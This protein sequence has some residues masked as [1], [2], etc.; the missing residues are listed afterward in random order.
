M[1]LAAHRRS[2][3]LCSGALAIAAAFTLTGCE[4]MD[5]F[6][7]PLVGDPVCER[8]WNGRWVPTG[9]TALEFEEDEIR[10]DLTLSQPPGCHGST[11]AFESCEESEDLEDDGCDTLVATIEFVRL[12]ERVFANVRLVE[13]DGE[14]LT[15]HRDVDLVE[16]RDV[17]GSK[18]AFS[19]IEGSNLAALID[20]GRLSGTARL[21]PHGYIISVSTGGSGLADVVAGNPS[22]F[23][24][25]PL[26]LEK[27]R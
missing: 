2:R 24:D 12:G 6:S 1:Q 8:A 23:E 16:I 22:L 9:E 13:I 14:P 4:N 15:V 26:L 19:R 21:G 11:V 20:E 3:T 17:S 7:E 18:A 10:I 27:V 25:M 5:Y